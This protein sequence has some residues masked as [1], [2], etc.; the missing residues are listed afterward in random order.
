MILG[1]HKNNPLKKTFC[2]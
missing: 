2:W 1:S